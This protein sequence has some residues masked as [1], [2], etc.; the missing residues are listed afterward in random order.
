[1]NFAM[2]QEWKN[3]L[4]RKPRLVKSDIFIQNLT[5]DE[6]SMIREASDQGLRPGGFSVEG[7]TVIL[8]FEREK[9]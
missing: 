2:T 4:L 9:A 6:L 5:L 8:R 7:N 1:M 3:G